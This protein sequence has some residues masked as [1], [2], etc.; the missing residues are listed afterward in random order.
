M[1]APRVAL[2]LDVGGA[3]QREALF[4]GDGEDDALVGVLE[5]VGV[6]VFEA[7]RHDD[8]AALHQAQALG[9]QR[10]AA[11]WLRHL[12]QEA[13][14]PRAGGVDQRARLHRALAAIARAQRCGPAVGAALRGHAGAARPQRGAAR[15]CIERVE[16]H[17]ARI[18]D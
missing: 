4:V 8:V 1:R 5:D 7:A 9:G 15:L 12:A 13:L 18:V 6:V 10:F 11:R 16:H 3:D 17:E 14:G 2:Q